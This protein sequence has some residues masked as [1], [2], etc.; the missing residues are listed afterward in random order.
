MG[1]FDEQI[2][3]RKKAEREL[4][5]DSFEL[6]ARSITGKSV[7]GFMGEGADVSNAVSRLLNYYHIPEKE[8]P[9]K[10]V[11]L[12]DRLDFLLSSTGILYREV[13]LEKGW[14]RDAMGVLITSLANGDGVVTVLPGKYGRYEYIDPKS[15][16]KVLLTRFTE[17]NLSTEALCFYR[18]LPQ[19][20][21]SVADL[22]KYMAECLDVWDFVKF[23]LAAFA[24]TL[25][26]LLMP[27]LNKLL[28]GT[29]VDYGEYRL[30]YAVI[31]FML[32]A[33]IGS[34]L[35]SV[36]RGLLLGTINIKVNTSV[37]A[38]AM[39]RVLS[40]PASF[41]KKYSAG[42]LNQY[43][44]YLDTLCTQVCSSVL[45]TGITGVF[46]LVYIFQIFS[47]AKSLVLPSILVTL[48]TIGISLLCSFYNV[49]RSKQIM[50]LS[51]KEQGLIFSL[52]SGV[53]K[54]R[55]T[56]AENRAFSKW[57]NL[58]AKGLDLTYNIPAFI[59]LNKVIT[60]AIRLAG[61]AVLYY[62]A[63]KTSVSVADYYA[64]NASYSYISSAFTALAA[65][66]VTVS[67][68]K[69]SLDILKPFLE[70]EPEVSGG[71]ETVDRLT[72]SIELSHVSF[73]YEEKGP[74]IL[75]DISLNIPSRQ[76]IAIVG[77]SGCGKSTLIRLLLG[78][79]MPEKGAIYY[80]KIDTRRLDMPS[81]RRQIG[82]VMQNGKLMAGSI[83]ENIALASPQITLDEAW[84]A[85]EIAG[86]ADSIKD[87]PMGMNTMLQEGIGGIS[88]GQRQRIM[89]AR[90]VAGKPKILIF[91]EATSALDNIT[92]KQVSE[93][94]DKMNC[95]RIVVAH[96]LS[97]I[98][99]CDR[100]IVL[101][102]GRIV[103]DGSYE[104]LMELG[105]SFAELVARQQVN[106]K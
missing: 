106:M 82:T 46:S 38:G 26:G 105:G 49:K 31:S 96:R 3:E 51:A 98:R 93:S 71:K 19:R 57:A 6:I 58:Y 81:V 7:T 64:F 40:M 94:L 103:E 79:E 35:F 66:I 42:E 104:E 2:E 21:L 59:R 41:F 68:I 91:D 70:A 67:S 77:K 52:I 86:M 18:P 48:L 84:E 25:I 65:I 33:S 54:I 39:M 61:T 44:N 9:K 88:G 1:W 32:F 13:R 28:I 15:G 17:G 69:P 47:F 4:L 80:N 11:S 74:L 22:F 100:I 50:E 75:N 34:I 89:I 14:H 30:L 5:N 72:G 97:T 62:V 53:Q 73:R 55:L 92:Q 60:Q 20:S 8:V 45:S 29:V 37:R 10:L 76:Y 99:H 23:G 101:D 83:F 43:L 87:M 56:G 78:F 102:Q 95:T 12:E 63:V 85:A 16:Q 27:R 24:I 36:I 90:A